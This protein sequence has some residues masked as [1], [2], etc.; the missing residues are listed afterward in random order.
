MPAQAAATALE[1]FPPVTPRRTQ[2][3]ASSLWTKLKKLGMGILASAFLTAISF[4]LYK[5]LWAW[6]AYVGFALAALC[7]IVLVYGAFKGLVGQC[8]YCDQLVGAEASGDALYVEDAAQAVWCKKCGEYLTLEKGTLRAHDPEVVSE[9]LSFDSHVYKDG[10]WPQ[11]C[12]LCGGPPE[13]HDDLRT[14]D[15]SGIALLMGRLSV[16]SG[17]VSGVP[18]CAAHSGAVK[19]K[20]EDEQLRLRWRSLPML[21]T[22]V[23]LNRTAGRSPYRK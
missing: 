18:Y 7:A 9:E 12:V 6:V 21:R 14:T 4:A 13:R 17:S 2:L 11:A 1:V 3:S 16:A 19:L 20:I 8:P 15:I 5:F 10:V 23:H 22:Y